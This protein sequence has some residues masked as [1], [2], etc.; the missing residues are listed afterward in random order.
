MATRKV[1][2]VVSNRAN[3]RDS[4]DSQDNSRAGSVGNRASREILTMD[5]I[6]EMVVKVGVM[7]A[8]ADMA[9]GMTAS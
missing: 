6:R 1:N 7:T 3:S 2:N 8:A 9:A 4:R 5:R